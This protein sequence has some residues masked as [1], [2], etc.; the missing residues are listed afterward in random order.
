[1]HA[2]ARGINDMCLVRALN[3]FQHELARSGFSVAFRENSCKVQPKYNYLRES[4]IK[5]NEKKKKKRN[6]KFDYLPVQG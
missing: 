6:L 3:V 2:R 5:K 1:M 4:S